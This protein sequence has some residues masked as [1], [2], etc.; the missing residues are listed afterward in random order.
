MY[1]RNGGD[2][3]FKLAV[4]WLSYCQFSIRKFDL[5]NDF[6]YG[7]GWS[8]NII[9]I[10]VLIVRIIDCTKNNTFLDGWFFNAFN[11]EAFKEAMLFFVNRFGTIRV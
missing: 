10:V 5:H 4:V 1:F 7:T 6:V 9:D 11:L 2:V 8:R 3:I